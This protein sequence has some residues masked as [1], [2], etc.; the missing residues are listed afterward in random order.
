MLLVLLLVWRQASAAAPMPDHRSALRLMAVPLMAHLLLSPTVH[1]W[2]ALLLL[3]FLPFLPPARRERWPRWLP[4]LPWL[5]LSGALIFSYL[6][7]LDPQN[8]AEREWVRQ[9]QWAPAYLLLL[10]AIAATLE[11]PNRRRPS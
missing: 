3:A 7:Y 8:F 4:A 2:Y 5:Y 9:L 11:L 10:A 1:P 6:T